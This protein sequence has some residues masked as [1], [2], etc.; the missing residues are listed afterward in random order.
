MK[1]SCK[2]PAD[3]L[4]SQMS[5][6]HDISFAA[7]AQTSYF[8]QYFQGMAG[9][10][11][12]LARRAFIPSVVTAADV[13]IGPVTM[14]AVTE[15]NGFGIATNVATNVSASFFAC[16]ASCAMPTHTAT[17]ARTTRHRPRQDGICQ[18]VRDE[19]RSTQPRH[20]H[21]GLPRLRVRR[22]PEARH[23]YSDH[24]GRHV[25][26]GARGRLGGLCAAASH[27]LHGPDPR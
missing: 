26:G 25:A 19:P 5:H 13:I 27:Q 20:R 15:I 12:G 6:K 24:Q 2:P 16:V 3:D 22:D 7:L 10:V 21:V 18:D 9:N 1:Q 4:L 8:V 23:S 17:L 14:Q 11:T